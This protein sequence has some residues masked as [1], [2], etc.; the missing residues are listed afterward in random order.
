[1]SEETKAKLRVAMTGKKHS[2]QTKEVLRQKMTGKTLDADAR[3][4]MS[5]SLRATWERKKQTAIALEKELVELR[6]AQ[7]QK[8][9][10]TRRKKVAA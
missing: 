1:M 4:R 2:E 6:K 8:T 9:V 5:A 7:E 10:S 3:A